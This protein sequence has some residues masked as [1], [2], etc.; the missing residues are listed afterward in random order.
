MH[1]VFE[2]G[3][4]ILQKDPALVAAMVSGEHEE[5]RQAALAEYMS[6]HHSGEPHDI[7]ALQQKLT[8]AH[9]LE[10]PHA[11]IHDLM[12]AAKMVQDEET[13]EHEIHMHEA[14]DHHDILHVEEPRIVRRH[15]DVEVHHP[16][17]HVDPIEEDFGLDLKVE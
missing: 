5:D 8:E 15:H 12:R 2:M 10:A 6:K 11:P 3:F 17:S 4:D 1:N 16:L 9:V 14:V 13:L 7:E